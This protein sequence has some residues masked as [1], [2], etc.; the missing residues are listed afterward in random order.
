[1]VSKFKFFF[2]KM[3]LGVILARGQ[4]WE[5]ISTLEAIL[6]W[7]TT[8]PGELPVYQVSFIDFLFIDRFLFLFILLRHLLLV[9]C[10]F[11]LP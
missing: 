6:A 9:I 8:R 5:T 7:E 3:T 11:Y 1:M 4:S 2:N 10:S